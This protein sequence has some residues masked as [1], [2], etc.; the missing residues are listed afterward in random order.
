MSD[1]FGQTQGYVYKITADYR[2]LNKKKPSYYIYADSAKNA[3]LKFEKTFTWLKV[4]NVEL[5]EGVIDARKMIV[6]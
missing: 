4:Y 1:N 5:Y 2:P 6:F 3:K